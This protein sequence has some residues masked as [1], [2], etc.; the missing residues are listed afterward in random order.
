M[1]G[2]AQETFSFAGGTYHYV[3]PDD[4]A[5]PGSLVVEIA[6]LGDM[7]ARFQGKRILEVGDSLKKFI[8]SS[9]ETILPGEMI[10]SDRRFDLIIGLGT[11]APSP[12]PWHDFLAKDGVLAFTRPVDPDCKPQHGTD[13]WYMRR[14]SYQNRWREEK[15]ERVK[16]CVEDWPFPGANAIALF[17]YPAPTE[18]K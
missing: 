14:V 16:H 9:H 12:H 2:V 10:T 5:E 17:R 11:I 18:A 3:L 7:L 15:W 4:S 8:G 1:I 6:I 13:S